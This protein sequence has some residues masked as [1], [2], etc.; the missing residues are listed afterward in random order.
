MQIISKEKFDKIDRDYK[1]VWQD[2]YGD[3]PEWKGRRTVMS[4][5]ISNDPNELGKLLI[6]GVHFLVDGDYNHLPVL[7][8][9]NAIVGAC[10]KFA[11]GYTQVREIYRVSEEYAKANE[12]IYLD[13]V[14]TTDGDFALPGSDLKQNLSNK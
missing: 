3:H 11:G 9:S 14:I 1:G 10:Y 13:R 2:Y 5:C 6:E 4:G 12:L 7:E 8:K